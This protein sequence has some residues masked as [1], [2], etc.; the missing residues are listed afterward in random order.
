MFGSGGQASYTTLKQKFRK[1]WVRGVRVCV[2]VCVV[3]A[4]V[5]STNCV[6]GSFVIHLPMETI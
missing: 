5:S 3:C 1:H 6:C 2:C 4:F